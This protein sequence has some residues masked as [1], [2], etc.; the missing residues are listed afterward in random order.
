M[1]GGGVEISAKITPCAHMSN[2]K[3]DLGS[4]SLHSAIPNSSLLK[5]G[6]DGTFHRI[7]D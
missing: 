1:L 2:I 6:I 7:S 4:K 5:Q 3:L